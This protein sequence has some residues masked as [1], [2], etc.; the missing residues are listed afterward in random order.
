MSLITGKE[1]LL[2]DIFSIQFSYKIPAGQRPYSWEERHAEDL[3]EDLYDFFVNN[4]PTNNPATNNYYFLGSIIITKKV[5][6]PD[7]EVTDGQQRLTTLTILLATIAAHFNGQAQAQIYDFIWE[8]GKPLLGIK[9]SPRLTI[10]SQDQKFFEDNIQAKLSGKAKLQAMENFVSGTNNLETESQMKIRANCGVFLK[11]IKE[12]FGGNVTELSNFVTFLMTR[13]NLVVVETD[14]SDTSYRVFTVINNR[15][16]SLSHADLIKAKIIGNLPSSQQK[17]YA[18][19]WEDL[20]IKATRQGFGDV[21]SH[22]RM[23]Y[24]KKKAQGTLLKEFNSFVMPKIEAAAVAVN[25]HPSVYLIDDLLE[26]Y[27]N[28]YVTMKKQSYSSNNS[29]VDDQINNLLMWLNKIDNDDWIPSTMK[30]FVDKSGDPN[31]LL[32][33][34]QKM[35]RLSA[36]M[37]ITSY[38]INQRILRYEKVLDEMEKNPNHNLSHPLQSV[39]LTDT[40]KQ[41]FLNALDG[42]I[43]RLTARRRSYVILRLDSFVATG[44]V[45]NYNPKILSIEHVLPQ[46][47]DKNSQWAKW[48]KDPDERDKWLHKIANLVPLT[49]RHN[50]A[51]SNY[52][53]DVKKTA[54][55]SKGGTISYPL[56]T[57]VVNE[58]DWKPSTVEARQKNLLDT[59]KKNWEL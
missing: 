20:E 42:E 56:T 43:Y 7:A 9:A 48:W 25:K 57:Q 13:C 22:L 59:F 12:T 15:G 19:E 40:E 29:A 24:I 16:M 38:S 44:Q 3:F 41:D 26:P 53:F 54:Y 39:E 37:H 31:Y 30:F 5:N 33:F 14:D 51:A 11:K 10:R 46:T 21:F 55:F 18:D 45:L 34:L 49:R 58:K 6:N 28:A 52:D 32:R 23:I 27:V 17:N 8:P 36:Y 47:V 50:S 1:Y 35:E 2:M 4:P